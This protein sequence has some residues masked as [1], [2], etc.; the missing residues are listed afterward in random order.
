MERNARYALVGLASLLIFV[1][2]IVFVV[3]LA[4]LQFTDQY[5]VYDVD[6]KGPVR[7]LSQGGEVFFNGI[8]VGE[9]TKLSLDRA[10]PNRV[11]A[12]IRIGADAPVR[13]NSIASLEPQG[14]TGVNYIQLTA[15]SISRPL[16]RD[17]TPR[18]VVP[19]VHAQQSALEGLLEGG[20]DVLARTVEALDR[21]NRLLSDANI[22]TF[23]ATLTNLKAD[24]QMI[25]EQRGTIQDLDATV[26]SLRA[27]SIKLDGLA[28]NANQLLSGDGRRTLAN[29][30]GAVG[31]LRGMVQQTRGVVTKL[32]GPTTQFANT[33][34]PELSRTLVTL[35][36]AAQDLDRVVNAVERNPRQALTKPAARE[37]QV[38][39]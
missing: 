22:A 15:G 24:T 14:I 38:K 25:S 11:V 32:E 9:V 2:L 3:W 37:L 20:G 26:K 16:L 34:L 4:R 35:R 7:G 1:G 12:R 31:D 6:F 17:I 30:N 36:T 29:L 18:G 21:A 10:N 5:A 19:V 27:T 13:S 33:G 23:S 28:D 8:K 39:P